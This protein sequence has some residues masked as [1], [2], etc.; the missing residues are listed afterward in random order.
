MLYILAETL[1]LAKT[2]IVTLMRMAPTPNTCSILRYLTEK[3]KNLEKELDSVN[4]HPS[5]PFF[6]LTACLGSFSVSQATKKIEKK[7]GRA[8]KQRS[9]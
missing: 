7:T 8:K 3:K 2:V 6:F 1:T 5:C 9:Y 4:H